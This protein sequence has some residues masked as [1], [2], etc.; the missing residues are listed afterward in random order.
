MIPMQT[1]DQQ[2]DDTPKKIRIYKHSD[3]FSSVYVRKKVS[4]IALFFTL[5]T[6]PLVL[7]IVSQRQE[8]QQHAA[9][10]ATIESENG[11]LAGAVAIGNDPSASGS[12]YIVF[13]TA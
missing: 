10:L 12:K 5:L 2:I 13:G 8:T 11:V 6:L 3:I 7:L 4:V 9:G 1:L